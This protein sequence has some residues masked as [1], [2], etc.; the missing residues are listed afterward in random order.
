MIDEVASLTLSTFIMAQDIFPTTP[1]E[2]HKYINDLPGH[3]IVLK[4]LAII[5]L[6]FLASTSI[7]M[8]AVLCLEDSH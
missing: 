5:V 2:I 3:D 7:D 8:E 6:E 1:Y 4:K